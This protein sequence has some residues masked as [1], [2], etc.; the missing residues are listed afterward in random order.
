MR[1]LNQTEEV[2]NIYN[3]TRPLVYVILIS[4]SLILLRI[5][6]LQIIRGDEYYKRSRNNFILS[7]KIYP[8]RG[9]ILTYDDKILA[10]T[11]P[12]F[13]ISVVPVFFSKYEQIT[14]QVDRLSSILDLSI[15]ERKRLVYKMKNCVG[16]CRHLPLVVKGE[17]PK[18]KILSYSSYLTS[19]PGTLISSSYKRVYPF[20][21]SAAHITGY[22]SKINQNELKKYTEYDSEDFTGKTGIEKW[23]ES[24]LHGSYG[25]A[26]QLIDYMGRKVELPEQIDGAVPPTKPAVKGNT[27]RTTVLSYLQETAAATLGEMAGA[28]VVMEVKTGR[29][30]ALYSGPSFDVNLFAR[31]RI[32]DM[33]WREYSQSIL[34][35]LVNK[36]IRQTYFP[37]STFKIIP[38][39]AGLYYGIVSPKST[40]NCYGCLSF[41]YET[42]CCWN[43]GGHGNVNLYQS[44]KYSC[45]I[46]Y[47][48][49]SQE[50]GIDRLTHFA[51]LFGVG[52]ATGIDLPNEESGILP[53]R[54]WF[55]MNYPGMRLNNGMIMN[56]SIGQGDVRM[57]P[58]QI[59]VA[60]AALANGGLV[61]KPRIIDEIIHEDGSV[62]HMDDEVVRVLDIKKS[63]F[64]SVTKSLWAVANEDGGTAFY[65]ADHTIPPAAG[66][67]GSSQVISNAARRNIDSAEDE[68]ILMTQDDALFAAFFPY[69]NPEI[70]AV[71]VVENGAH[72]GSTAAPIVY[73]MLRAYHMK[74]AILK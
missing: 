71:A 69:K 11:E 19:F 3:K 59:A 33:V 43:H 57:T 34:H 21:E 51:S 20:G 62:E 42:K 55:R 25:E 7:E 32:P 4:F 23:Y 74:T 45:D 28:I 65:H 46:Y 73:K 35:P 63:Y 2:K 72:G 56:L 37:G 53:T 64:E 60:Y 14:E 66:K 9:D 18:K 15:N 58:L 39:L 41:G 16:T 31:E 1:I 47:Y 48:F 29:V 50:L 40:F 5:F 26:F 22:V 27:V 30:L 38:A 44:L 54:E 12:S 8:A 13:K 70:V 61:M 68:R 24:T 49:L 17:I 6:V 67:T 52:S 10:T 36:T